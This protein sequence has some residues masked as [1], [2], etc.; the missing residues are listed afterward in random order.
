MCSLPCDD[1]GLWCIETWSQQ[2]VISFLFFSFFS[3]F[4][5]IQF[6]YFQHFVCVWF[7]PKIKEED[8]DAMM[9]ESTCPNCIKWTFVCVCIW[10]DGGVAMI[11]LYNDLRIHHLINLPF[12][13]F[14]F[15]HSYQIISTDETDHSGQYDNFSF[16][17]RQ[18]CQMMRKVNETNCKL[19]KRHEKKDFS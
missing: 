2:L 4:I 3:S 12:F 5:P 7:G 6:D 10:R 19:W 17:S 8:D 14:F 16:Y 13:F 9:V 11:L 15:V 1:Y 18:N